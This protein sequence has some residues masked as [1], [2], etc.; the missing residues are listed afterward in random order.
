MN[1][2][3]QRP[4]VAWPLFM[5]FVTGVCY[6]LTYTLAGVSVRGGIPFTAYVFWLGLGA[7][8]IMF[9]ISLVF[10]KV[11][12]FTL[13][14]LKVYFVT[15]V[16]GFVIPYTI[17]A[18]VI[19]RGLPPGIMSMIIALAPMMTYL[20]A[21][22]FRIERAWWIK[23][24]G[25]IVGIAGIV[26]IVAP[27]NSL[28]SPDLVIWALIAL[29][30]PF[31]YA[32][33][34]IAA[35][36][37]RPPAMDSISFSVGYFVTVVPILFGAM[38]VAGEFWA[39]DGAFGDAEWALVLS[40][41]IQGLG[42]YLFLELV[43]LM[44]PVFFTAVNFITPLTGILFGW[45]FFGDKLSSWVLIALVPLFLGLVFVILPRPAAK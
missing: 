41:A 22:I 34:T 14:H 43:M 19:G 42:I 18:V 1:G 30:V 11:P 25:L 28:P 20:G 44:G 37:M 15:G 27:A 12:R 6:G 16:T 35:V 29:I 36:L 7:G 17:V 31:G 26:L 2:T 3:P 4:H 32:A 39:F 13:T 23:Y 33:T 21:V 24:L 9:V 5:L 38:L 40:A 45:A 8:A 10:R